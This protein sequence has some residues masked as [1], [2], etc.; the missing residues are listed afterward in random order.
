MS[1]RCSEP[2][3][4]LVGD[5]AIGFGNLEL[6]V[7]V[8]IWQLFGLSDKTAEQLAQAITA[9][10][11]FD[12]KVRA[13]ASMYK[14]RFPSQAGDSAFQKVLGRLIEAESLRNQVLHSSW[15]KS[16]DPDRRL[17]VKSSAKMKHGLK[18]TVYTVT[19]QSLGEVVKTIHDVGLELAEFVLTNIQTPISVQMTGH[20]AQED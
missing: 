9:E 14:I 7:S 1:I 20:A 15:P 5:V 2:I 6:F 12:R 16:E 18:N 3:A 10:M 19:P 4:H 13:F 17:R 11:S 8:A